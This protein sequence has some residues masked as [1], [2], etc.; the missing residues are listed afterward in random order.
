MQHGEDTPIPEKPLPVRVRVPG[1]R[2]KAGFWT[3]REKIAPPSWSFREVL[4]S[5]VH[6]GWAVYELY[7]GEYT[8]CRNGETS[9]PFATSDLELAVQVCQRWAREFR[10]ALSW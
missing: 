3:G 2:P 9:G 8:V 6:G 4:P 5:C 10:T 7:P 1:D